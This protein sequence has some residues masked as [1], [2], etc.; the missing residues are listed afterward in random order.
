MDNGFYTTEEVAKM[1]KVHI[2]TVRR[3]LEAGKLRG[4]KAGRQW[5][6]KKQDLEEYLKSNR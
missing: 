2:I 1:L 6:I 4:H 3:W 5:R